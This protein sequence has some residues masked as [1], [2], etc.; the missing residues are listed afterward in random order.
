M[1]ILDVSIVNVAIATIQSDLGGSTADVA[2]ITTAYSL[3]LGVV[4]PAS[5]WLGDRFGLDRVYM[6]SLA[7]LRPRLSAMWAGVEP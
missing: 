6:I 1:S 2:W 5:A 4:V 7:D 3:V